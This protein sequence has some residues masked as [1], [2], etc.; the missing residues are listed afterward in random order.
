MKKRFLSMLFAIM[1]ICTLF[2]GCKEE[3]YTVTA[4]SRVAQDGSIVGLS[5]E[6]I[7]IEVE[8]DSIIGNIPINISPFIKDKYRF[9]GW[10]TDESYTYQWNTATDIVVGDMTLYAKWEE[11]P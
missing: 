7:V 3:I 10:F 5:N 4:V 9:C 11:I 1:L 6:T 8:K 2:A